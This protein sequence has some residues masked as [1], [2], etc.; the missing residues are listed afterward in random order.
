[1][2]NRIVGPSC[3]NNKN[4]ELTAG[5]EGTVGKKN[6]EQNC[7]RNPTIL[8]QEEGRR[9]LFAVYNVVK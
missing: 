8:V 3:N 4:M 1:M 9:T 2:T 6:H 7:E 5:L